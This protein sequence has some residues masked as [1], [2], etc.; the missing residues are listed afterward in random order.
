MI[1][2][3]KI[4]PMKRFSILKTLSV[5][6][7][8]S[9]LISAPLTQTNVKADVDTDFT[10]SIT[11]GA[12]VTD[13]RDSSRVTVSNA[14][15]SMSSKA[16]SFDC[17]TTSDPSTASF[18][19]NSQRIYVD[20]PGNAQ[21]GS[22]GWVLSVAASNPTDVWTAASNTFDFNDSGTSG[23][24]DG[25]DADTKGGQ[26]TVDPSVGT[27][28]TDCGS[29]TTTNVTK[30]TAFTFVEG[31][32]NSITLL[33][34]AA[35]SDDIWRGYLTGVGIQQTIPAEQPVANNYTLNLVV[36]VVAN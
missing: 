3:R 32:R 24:T 19:S 25:A 14:S 31:T 11:A 12:L 5:L 36:S 26:M 4:L 22:N 23:C 28:T 18:G 15:V 17:Y 2:T 21:A 6:G 13:I 30:G 27:L 9:M 20:N 10:Q 7:I 33:N 16:F 34:A 8:A 1:N 29:C 35:E